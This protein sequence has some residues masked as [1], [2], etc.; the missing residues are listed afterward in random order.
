[1]GTLLLNSAREIRSKLRED[2]TEV[3]T[4]LVPKTTWLKLGESKRKYMAKRIPRLLQVYGKYLTSADRLG[5][6]AGKT[7][8]QS[9]SSGMDSLQRLNVRLDTGS[10]ALLGVLAQAHGVSRCFLFNYLLWLEEVGIGN[11]IVDILNEGGP[12]F[13]KSYSYILHLDLTNNEIIRRL[14][15][16]PEHSFYVSNPGDRYTEEELEN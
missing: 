2:K 3:V 4:L 11:S 9:S 15:C 12:T 13:H 7:T 6:K 1:M 8:Y 5:K 16:E 10:W 14:R